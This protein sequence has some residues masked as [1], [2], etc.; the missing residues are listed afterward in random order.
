M[1]KLFFI[2]VIGTAL[3]A[4]SAMADE[5]RNYAGNTLDVQEIHDTALHNARAAKAA[6]KNIRGV[7]AMDDG[8]TLSLYQNG[9]AFVAEVSGQAGQRVYRRRAEQQGHAGDV[10]ER[11]GELQ[12]MGRL[13]RC[14][15]VRRR[16]TEPGERHGTTSGGHRGIVG[17]RRG[18]RNQAHRGR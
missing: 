4:S 16:T 12:G 3:G 15:A 9:H 6:F 2:A 5:S 10:I 13:I 14:L 18:G 8:T 11:H 1:K 17:H 7:Y